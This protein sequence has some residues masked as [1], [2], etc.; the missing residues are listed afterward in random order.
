MLTRDE[1]DGIHIVR[2]HHGRANALDL[3]FLEELRAQFEQDAPACVL[4]GTG[5]IFSAG[6]DLRRFLEEGDDY[7]D[8]FLDRLDACFRALFTTDVPHVACLNGHAIAGGGVLAFACDET[9]A[10]RGAGRIGVPEL[11]VGVPFPAM[12]LEI[13][14]DRA[15]RATWTRLLL[16]GETIPMEEAAALGIVDEVIE[17]DRLEGRSIERARALA[18]ICPAAFR[19]TKRALRR[20]AME[21]YRS[22]LAHEGKL[23]A[24]WKSDAC[25]DAMRRYVERTLGASRER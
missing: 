25:R 11:L 20:P 4:V 8:A 5:S 3:E 13:V 18:D 22:A 2:M 15:P 6:V 23:R 7:V 12:P 17:A 9:I 16:R 24:V 21:R 1:R 10:G 14:R 19:E